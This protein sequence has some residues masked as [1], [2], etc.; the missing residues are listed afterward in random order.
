M[1]SVATVTSNV[2]IKAYDAKGHVNQTILIRAVYGYTI[3]NST[4]AR[5]TYTGYVDVSA[6]DQ[7]QQEQI[8]F[9]LNP[10]ESRTLSNQT[11]FFRYGAKR[12]GTF[13]IAAR[14]KI[15]NEAVIYEAGSEATLTVTM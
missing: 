12:P 6:D 3:T 4:D 8:T 10:G 14:I 15:V 9:A 5:R 2:A 1:E 13:P 7:H 11:I